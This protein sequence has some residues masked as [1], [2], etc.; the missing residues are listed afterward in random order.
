MA[1]IFL[2]ATFEAELI[3]CVAVAASIDTSPATL[4]ATTVCVT[5]LA[6]LDATTVCVTE[7][8]SL[9]AATITQVIT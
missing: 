1:P 3:T 5:E 9:D 8:A 4:D 6:S 2:S 7:L